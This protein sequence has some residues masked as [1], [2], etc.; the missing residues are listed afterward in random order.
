MGVKLKAGLEGTEWNTIWKEKQS[1]GKKASMKSFY[2]NVPLNMKHHM[3]LEGKHTETN[4]DCW[5]V[6]LVIATA[7]YQEYSLSVPCDGPL[8][9]WFLLQWG[10]L[11]WLC[12]V[13]II[14]H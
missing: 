2:I 6:K 5:E 10:K 3:N 9:I 13:G 1:W 12:S 11:P 14:I 7:G 8:K 4:A